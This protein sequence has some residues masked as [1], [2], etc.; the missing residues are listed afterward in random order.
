MKILV[1]NAGSSS[2]KYQLFDSTDFSVLAK[3]LCECI[4]ISGGAIKHSLACGKSLTRS[5]DLPTH[6]TAMKLLCEI[7][8][9]DD[10]GC[11]ADMSEIG[12][13]GHRFVHGGSYFS[14]STLLTD[15][16]LKIT[17]KCGELAP[18]HTSAHMQGI[19]GCNEVMPGVPQVLVF[20]TAFHQTIPQK[21]YM[22]PI[23][24][25]LYEEHQIR[26][27]GFHGTSHLYVSE[28][29]AKVLGGA[30]GTKI[31]T[32][33]LG[34]GSSISAVKDG[35]SIDTSMGFTP[36]SGIEMG[37]RC[38]DI[39]PAIVAFIMQKKNI[40]ADKITDYMNKNCGF[41]GIS[42]TSSD[43]REI[44]AEIQNGGPKAEQ[45][46]LAVDILG[47]QIKK[48][49]GS[50]SAAMGGVDA[51]VFTAGIGENTPKIRELACE[52]LEYLGVK[53]DKE[54][55]DA[56]FSSGGMQA[57]TTADSKVKVY[58]IPTNEEL[59]IARDTYEIVKG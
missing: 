27:Y 40:S 6:A 1:V 17:D 19:A 4:G 35:K 55:N 20:D 58:M 34:N 5:V 37:T 54:A 22:Y 56:T 47:Y 39:D 7:L 44:F 43:M 8:V 13:I 12:A 33:H 30:Q 36:L 16:V 3:G 50:Y 31:V 21:A 15:E 9:S 59:I 52:G 38:G 24:Y 26:R 32:C 11:I 57:L 2:L 14:G 45:C 28:E 10:Y 49:I 42:E 53:F 23:P 41:L 51:I 29:M 18:L 48:Y 46:Q 25:A